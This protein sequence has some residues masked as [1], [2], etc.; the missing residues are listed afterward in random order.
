MD[1]QVRFTGSA[2]KSSDPEPCGGMGGVVMITY[3]LLLK[4]EQSD[5][6]GEQF[7][8]VLRALLRRSLAG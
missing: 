1:F 2:D 5:P 3:F 4:L 8:V 7:H 6:I